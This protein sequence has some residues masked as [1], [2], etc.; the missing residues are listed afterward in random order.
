M[1]MLEVM[2][3]AFIKKTDKWLIAPL[4]DS[5]PKFLEKEILGAGHKSLLD[6]GCGED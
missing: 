5:Y 1:L 6:I 2:L 4:V 3:K